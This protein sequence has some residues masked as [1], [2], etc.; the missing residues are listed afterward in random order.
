MKER[1]QWEKELE[2]NMI[3]IYEDMKLSKNK[4]IL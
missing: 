3:E 1:G 4:Y 2:L